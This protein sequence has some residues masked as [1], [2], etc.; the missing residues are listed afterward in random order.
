MNVVVVNF[1]QDASAYEALTNL[2]ELDGQG[3]IHLRAAAVVVRAEDGRLTVKDE[4]SDDSFAGTATG[5]TLGLLIGIIGGPL[6]MLIGGTTGL[7]MG[8]LFDLDD[9]EDTESVL[10]EI[11]RSV[12]VGATALLAE[13]TEQS[14]QVLDAAMAKLSGT[15]LRRPVADVEAEIAAAADAQR[16]AKRQARK[17]LFEKRRE[18]HKA[19]VHAKVEEL[20]SKLHRQKETAGTAG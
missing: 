5:G 12:P 18:E 4:V 20:K 16:A 9:D 7:M 10:S 11:S 3:Q 8:S 1:D 2:K 15:V 14:P 17:E 6:G 13:L 19:D